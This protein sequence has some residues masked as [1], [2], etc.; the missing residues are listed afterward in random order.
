MATLQP[1]VA[2]AATVMREPRQP[3]HPVA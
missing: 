2:G 1:G 3:S